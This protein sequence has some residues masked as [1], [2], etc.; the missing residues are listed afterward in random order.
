MDMFSRLV[1]AGIRPDCAAETIAWF[2]Q[3]EDDHGL[4]QYIRTAEERYEKH[5]RVLQSKPV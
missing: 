5:L 3:Q 2:R 1:T 4:E